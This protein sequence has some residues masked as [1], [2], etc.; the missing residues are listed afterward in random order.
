MQS[1]VNLLN[2]DSKHQAPYVAHFD[3]ALPHK[4]LL[5][6]KA[7]DSLQFC[8]FEKRNKKQTMLHGENRHLTLRSQA[9]SRKKLMK[10]VKYAIGVYD[11]RTKILSMVPIAQDHM[12]NLSQIVKREPTASIPTRMLEKKWKQKGMAKMVEGLGRS[13]ES[14]KIRR[15]NVRT[16]FLKQASAMLPFHDGDTQE[17][18]EIYPLDKCKFSFF[19]NIDIDS[20]I[21]AVRNTVIPD[22]CAS[23]LQFENLA[24]QTEDQT[25]IS[26][27]L[28][29]HKKANKEILKTLEFLR[30]LLELNKSLSVNR[31]NIFSHHFA[32]T[33]GYPSDDI[34]SFLT[35]FSSSSALNISSKPEDQEIPFSANNRNRIITWIIVYCLVLNHY[36]LSNELIERLKEETGVSRQQISKFAQLAGAQTHGEEFELTAPLRI[37]MVDRDDWYDCEKTSFH[38]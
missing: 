27:L 29:K 16:E 37:T 34:T 2:V 15:P 6:E 1:K 10:G 21:F 19:I 28:E 3:S 38:V 14:S 26:T 7:R 17:V 12:F 13:Q 18:E 11:Q 35:F 30:L 5:D 36:T 25:V 20:K 4:N 31:V 23:F 33:V 9:E 22:E 24:W 8:A 32:R